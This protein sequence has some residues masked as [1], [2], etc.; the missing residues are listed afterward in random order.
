MSG[1]GFW[2]NAGCL[3]ITEKFCLSRECCCSLVDWLIL[4]AC[5]PLRGYFMPRG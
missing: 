5:Q 1:G 2:I 4:I 3:L